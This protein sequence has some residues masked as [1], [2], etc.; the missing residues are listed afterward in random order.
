M[1]DFSY[2]K[3]ALNKGDNA[4]ATKEY[5]LFEVALSNGLGYG[6]GLEKKKKIVK[7]RNRFIKRKNA[8]TPSFSVS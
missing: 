7:R 6:T 2:Q 1:S 4:P 5:G 8:L 3:N